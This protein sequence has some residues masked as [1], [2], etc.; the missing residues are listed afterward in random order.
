VLPLR[1]IAQGYRVIYEPEAVLN[2]QTLSE[3]A[4][5]FRMR[6]RVALR[7]LWALWD[8][9]ELLSPARSGL[10]AWQLASHKLLRYGSFLPLGIAAVLNWMLVPAGSVYAAAAIGQVIFAAMVLLAYAGPTRLASRALPRFCGYFLLLNLASCV[11][12]SRF[13]RGEKQ[14]LWKPRMG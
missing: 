14:V 3:S 2:E 5:E 12:V 7:A 10:F 11:A 6:V 4:A 13:I 9:R 1:V 8:N